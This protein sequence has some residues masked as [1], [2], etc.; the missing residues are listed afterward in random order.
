MKEMQ[1]DHRRTNSNLSSVN[2]SVSNGTVTPSFESGTSTARGAGPTLASLSQPIFEESEAVADLMTLQLPLLHNLVEM[3]WKE[4]QPWCPILHRQSVQKSFETLTPPLD[5]IEDITLRALISLTVIH[6]SQ[7]ISLGYKGRRRLSLHLRSQVLVEALAKPSLSSL[8]ALLIIAVLDL[9]SDDT[10]STWGLLSV[11]RRMCEQTGLFRKL[12]KHIE[13]QNPNHIGLPAREAFQGEELAIP[14]TWVTLALDSAST[15]GNSWRDASAALIDHLSSIAYASTPDFSDS[16][17]TMTHLAAI[18]LQPLHGLLY[19]REHQKVPQSTAAQFATCDEIYQNLITYLRSQP[20]TSYTLLA[21]GSID[22]DPNTVLT[23]MLANGAVIVLYQGY[24]SSRLAELYR[25]VARQRCIQACEAMITTIRTVS[26]ADT[27]LSSPL[28][29]S[30]IFVAARL[31]VALFKQG[32]LTRHPS[33]DVL[34][35]G[36]NMCGRR[37]PLARRH[38][39]VLRAAIM[40]IDSHG[41]GAQTSLPTEFWDLRKSALDI[42]DAMKRWIQSYK[43][44]LYIGS[45]NGPYA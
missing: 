37:W 9:G 3:W 38:D 32:A 8:Q 42:D 25:S 34:M 17:R 44:S 23:S 35:H 7:A 11:C 6:S 26:D 45:L 27:E 43:P 13:H 40:E 21:D 20:A 30:S 39:I 18:G 24:L 5:H 29:A 22:F 15:L 16:F 31:Q 28:L 12:L 14:L 41:I 4:I 1:R 33:F 10:S 2:G 19:E 36:L